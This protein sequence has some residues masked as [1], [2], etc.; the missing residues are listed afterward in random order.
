MLVLKKIK[1]NLKVTDLSFSATQIPV[2]QPETRGLEIEKQ[3]E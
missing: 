2:A 3:V 1:E